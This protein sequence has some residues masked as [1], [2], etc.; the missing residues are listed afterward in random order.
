MVFVRGECDQYPLVRNA[1]I[2][3]FR[4]SV[5]S[6]AALRMQARISRSFSCALL[7]EAAIYS[8]MV[9]GRGLAA[10]LAI[11]AALFIDANHRSEPH[12]VARFRRLL[13]VRGFYPEM[14][15]FWEV[16]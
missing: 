7:G 8:S 2:P 5:A 10:M 12:R 16:C 13:E 4:P 3:H 6:G 11:V 1:G 15:H 9:L 14:D